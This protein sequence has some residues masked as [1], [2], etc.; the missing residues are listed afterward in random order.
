M[1]HD[2]ERSQSA[3]ATYGV[4]LLASGVALAFT[5]LVWPRLETTPSPLFF[6]AVVVSSCYGGLRAALLAT[7]LAALATSYFFVLPGHSIAI[8]SVS[9]ALGLGMF[10]LVAA[11]TGSLSAARRRAETE[12][13]QQAVIAELGRLALAGGELSGLMHE[14][15]TQVARTLGIEYAAVW[16]LVPNARTSLR[17]AVC[18]RKGIVEEV[19]LD[20]DLLSETSI[21]I[22]DDVTIHGRGGVTFVKV[23]IRGP[24]GPLGVLSAHA[25]RPRP[26]APHDGH[27]LQAVAHVLGE[28]ITRQRADQERA[29]LLARE[30]R[31]RAQAEAA[32]RAKEDLLATVSHELRTPLTQLVTWSRL[33][34]LGKGDKTALD[35]IERSTR[36]LEQLAGD[37]LD[38]AR[39]TAGK[40]ALSLRPVALAGAVAEA[41]D[42]PRVAARAKEIGLEEYLDA[43]PMEVLGDPMRLQQVVWNLVGNAVKFTPHGGRVVVRLRSVRDRA[44]LTVSDTGRGI[45]AAFLPHVFEP[46]RQARAGAQQGLGLGLAIVRQLV[47]LHGGTVRAESPGEGRGARFTVTLPLAPAA[48]EAF[49]SGSMTAC[50]S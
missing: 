45:S 40:L 38:V 13:G 11:L 4:A 25:A 7:A 20:P 5:L 23:I 9:D 15:A 42:A 27:F 14:A 21:E 30:R 36:A 47:E 32:S 33:L 10:A 49:G 18:C 35:A 48:T 50:A 16:Q 3:L 17:T 43:G 12:R 37:L 6:A 31:A 26:L 39:I 2:V 28:A 19:T 22:D 41:L 24:E 8:E 34:R 44:E 29:A 46:F 1:G